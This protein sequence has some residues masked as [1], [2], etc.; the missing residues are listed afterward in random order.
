MP[1]TMTRFSV[2]LLAI[3]VAA[4]CS[5]TPPPLP[6]DVEAVPPGGYVTEGMFGPIAVTE[7]EGTRLRSLVFVEEDGAGDI[8]SEL[9]VTRPGDLLVEYC[10]AM[11]VG[12][13]FTR[14]E[15]VLI[16]GLGGGAMF[17][18]LQEQRRAVDVTA[19]EIDPTVVRLAERFF[20]VVPDRRHHIVTA[21]ALVYLA[22]TDDQWDVIFMD[23]FL[24]PGE[25]T[26]AEGAPRSLSTVAFLRSLH[27]RLAPGGVVVF[28]LVG[29]DGDYSAQ[30][31]EI[32]RAFAATWSFDVPAHENRVVVASP[33]RRSVTR[34][35][36]I[37]WASAWD[38]RHAANFSLRQIVA[39]WFVETEDSGPA[40]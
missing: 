21:D 6:P 27:P 19:V 16:V 10:Q 2:A 4:A 22:E 25:L 24:H 26:D 15:R 39:D 9:D 34:D 40:K 8:Q 28:N 5:T 29:V 18:F 23:A 13:L 3:A 11:F 30:M 38:E 14:P 36:L 1:V 7:E 31:S 17:R 32:Q 12:H 35:Q 33:E 37:E 20:G